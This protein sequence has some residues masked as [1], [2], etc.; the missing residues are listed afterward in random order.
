MAAG[1]AVFWAVF[2]VNPRYIMLNDLNFFLPFLA[3]LDNSESFETNF[4]F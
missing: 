4:F 3:K 1:L 2:R